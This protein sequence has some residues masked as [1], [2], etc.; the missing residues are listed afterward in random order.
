MWYMILIFPPGVSA[1]VAAKTSVRCLWA[2]C[3][4]HH[5]RLIGS[6]SGIT[7]KLKQPN[8]VQ[9]YTPYR[10][11]MT[12]TKLGDIKGACHVLTSIVVCGRTVYQGLFIT[13]CSCR[14]PGTRWL[15]HLPLDKL[16]VILAD[17]FKYISLNQTDRIPNPISLKFVPNWQ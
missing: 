17:I 3:Q 15:T 2:L 6:A 1:I 13:D 11:R 10:I 14:Y 9:V 12:L 8:I 7:R 16:A 5:T 4:E